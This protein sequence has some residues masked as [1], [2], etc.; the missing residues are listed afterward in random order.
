ML[1]LGLIMHAQLHLE[2]MQANFEPCRER[3]RHDDQALRR[4]EWGTTPT[5]HPG[6]KLIMKRILTAVV[7]IKTSS[8]T[9]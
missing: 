3:M 6:G 2:R 5:L 1:L 7:G 4:S 8:H 9:D